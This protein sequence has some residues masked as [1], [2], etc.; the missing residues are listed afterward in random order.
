[1]VG[2]DDVYG[3][4]CFL[5]APEGDVPFDERAESV[6]REQRRHQSDRRRGKARRLEREHL[7]ASQVRPD[8]RQF[9]ERPVGQAVAGDKDGVEGA[10]RGADEQ[11]GLDPSGGEGLE[12]PNL[13][14]SKAPAA[15][16]HERRG[17]LSR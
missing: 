7:T 9:A 4:F 12:H 11:V 15:R 3:N 8:R 2:R 6:V 14:R 17:H 13:Y 10:G 16:Q 5:E 1:V